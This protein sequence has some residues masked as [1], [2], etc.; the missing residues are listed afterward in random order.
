[1]SKTTHRQTIMRVMAE[2][3]APYFALQRQRLRTGRSLTNLSDIVELAAPSKTKVILSP[4][5]TDTENVLAKKILKAYKKDKQL[6]TK[7]AAGDLSAIY[8][9][10][11]Q[12]RAARVNAKFK[13]KRGKD[14][15]KPT[16]VGMGKP[17]V[18]MNGPDG[19]GDSSS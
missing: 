4:N 1:M 3:A 17:P 15:W 19:G 16:K 13:D 9:K 8:T 14:V 7:E 18:G 10:S 6:M 2:L 12:K 11:Q 5:V